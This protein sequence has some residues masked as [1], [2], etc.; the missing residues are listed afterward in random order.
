MGANGDPVQSRDQR[1]PKCGAHADMLPLFAHRRV[2]PVTC[3]S[4]GTKLRRVFPGL[5]YYTLSFIAALMLEASFIP[6]L[7]LAVF[8]QWLW[9]AVIVAVLLAFNLSTSAFLNSRTRV[10]FE[11]PEDARRDEPGRWYPDDPS[12]S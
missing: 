9:I 10:E 3:V 12:A 2:T 8:Q 5:P 6:V 11:N 7:I 1:C 4:C